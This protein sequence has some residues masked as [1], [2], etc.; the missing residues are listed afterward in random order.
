MANIN[1]LLGELKEPPLPVENK[2]KAQKKQH[3]FSYVET[4]IRCTMCNFLPRKGEANRTECEGFSTAIVETMKGSKAK[5]HRFKAAGGEGRLC[6]F[7]CTKCGS[8]AR[9]VTKD[10]ARKCSGVPPKAGV[11]ASRSTRQ[12]R[13]PLDGSAFEIQYEIEDMGSQ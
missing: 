8:H 13:G 2:G 7:W 11:C 3:C 5:W 10:L 4:Q 12:G 1:Q 6:T 9:I